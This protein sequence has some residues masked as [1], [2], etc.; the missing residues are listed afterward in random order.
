M[1]SMLSS[2]PIECPQYLLD[3]AS[4]LTPAPTAI[5]N[6]GAQLP[7]ESAKEAFEKKLD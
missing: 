6:A 5:V 7:M 4:A 2:T 3:K 1:T